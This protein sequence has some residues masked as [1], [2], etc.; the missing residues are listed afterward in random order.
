MKNK[1]KMFTCSKFCTEY[2][3]INFIILKYSY[4]LNENRYINYKSIKIFILLNEL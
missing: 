2:F 4:L 1:K 3:K